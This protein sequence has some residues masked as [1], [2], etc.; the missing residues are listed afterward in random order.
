MS[1]NDTEEREIKNCVANVLVAS[2]IAYQSQGTPH[3]VTIQRF[4]R[5]GNLP[6]EA[7][8]MLAK[9]AVMKKD[10]AAAFVAKALKNLE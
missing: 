4:I 2:D 10:R 9:V 6:D 3:A 5:K 1:R 8:R 7:R